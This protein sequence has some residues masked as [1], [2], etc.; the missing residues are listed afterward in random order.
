MDKLRRFDDFVAQ[1]DIQW[2]SSTP[3][4]TGFLWRFE[5]DDPCYGGWISPLNERWGMWNKAKTM[6]VS[7][8][9]N[10]IHEGQEW[11]RLILIVRG[12]DLALYVNGE[13]LAFA[14]DSLCRTGGVQLNVHASV[15]G[16]HVQLDNLKVWDISSLTPSTETPR[17]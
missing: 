9:S 2:V 4:N 3:G 7:G 17:Q 1:V 14:S 6:D 10:H 16:E 12:E 13:P 15:P 5:R 8:W 11:N